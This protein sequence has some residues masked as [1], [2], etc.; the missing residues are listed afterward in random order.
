MDGVRAAPWM[1][2]AR[3]KSPD[4]AAREAPATSRTRAE[5]RMAAAS[6]SNVGPF[7]GPWEDDHERHRGV[8]QADGSSGPAR[9]A[10]ADAGAD[11]AD[12]PGGGAGHRDT[13]DLDAIWFY[14]I[15]SDQAALEAHAANEARLA[16]IGAKVQ[17]L[18]AKPIE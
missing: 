2:P 16:H 10:R 7:P 8:R 12:G 6:P 4:E 1:A 15:F 9:R 18:L 11:D 17:A 14:E 5:A 3:A 13:E